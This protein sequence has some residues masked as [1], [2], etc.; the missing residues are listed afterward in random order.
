MLIAGTVSKQAGVI[1]GG[2]TLKRS[3]EYAFL[4][5][6]YGIGVCLWPMLSCGDGKPKTQ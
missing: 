5:V 6:P 3:G 2:E 4:L 1:W